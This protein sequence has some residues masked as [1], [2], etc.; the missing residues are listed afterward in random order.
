MSDLPKGEYSDLFDLYLTEPSPSSRKS[1]WA[2]PDLY[3]ILKAKSQ[4][5]DFFLY[6]DITCI[7]RY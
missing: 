6:Q 1:T 4:C 7:T 3:N 2:V 5:Q